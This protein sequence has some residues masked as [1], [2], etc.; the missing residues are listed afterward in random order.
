MT[1]ANRDLT[2]TPVPCLW[3][4]AGSPGP[5]SPRKT[6]FEEGGLFDFVTKPSAGPCVILLGLPT[7]DL[8]PTVDA[9]VWNLNPEV[10]KL[11]VVAVFPPPAVGPA[12]AKRSDLATPESWRQF[13]AKLR[14]VHDKAWYVLLNVRA[15]DSWC[16]NSES[17]DVP[18]PS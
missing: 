18:A 10:R 8:L 1:A 14:E 9:Y 5:Q 2:V 12:G 3:C 13:E 6:L 15:C 16:W 17:Q 4:T 7:D 11:V